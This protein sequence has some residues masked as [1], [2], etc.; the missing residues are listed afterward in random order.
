M[1]REQRNEL[2]VQFLGMADAVE[3]LMRENNRLHEEN[4]RLNKLLEQY[5]ES[6]KRAHQ[7]LF[8]AAGQM[9]VL[10]IKAVNA[11]YDLGKTERKDDHDQMQDMPQE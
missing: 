5:Y 1:D 3:S 7:A 10:A 9:T 4:K 8:N 6:D 11:G 2:L